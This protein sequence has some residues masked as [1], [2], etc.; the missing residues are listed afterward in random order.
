MKLVVQIPVNQVQD[1]QRPPEAPAQLAVGSLNVEV[2]KAMNKNPVSALGEWAQARHL[3]CR[4]E[5]VD[6]SGP[7]HKPK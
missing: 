2:L 3:E 1:F 5:C 7:P 4:I 6:Q